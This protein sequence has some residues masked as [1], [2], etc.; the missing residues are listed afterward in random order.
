MSAYVCM[1][2]YQPFGFVMI[3]FLYVIF[4]TIVT[5]VLLSFASSVLT[6]LPIECRLK[7]TRHIYV[8]TMELA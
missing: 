8:R 6:S 4:D 1:V 3:D 5:I 7:Y 2:M